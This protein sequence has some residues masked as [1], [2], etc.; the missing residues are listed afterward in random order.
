MRKFSL[1]L[2]L[3]LTIILVSCDSTSDIVAGKFGELP[4]P[5]NCNCN[6][7]CMIIIPAILPN[8]NNVMFAAM[9]VTGSRMERM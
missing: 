1:A 4:K 7:N 3:V 9:T 2:F 5:S 6:G 8:N